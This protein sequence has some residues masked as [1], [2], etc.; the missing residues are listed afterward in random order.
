M[1]LSD[2]AEIQ[3]GLAKGRRPDGATTTR[4]YLRVANV[5]DGRL[6]LRDVKEIVVRECNVNKYTLRRGDVLMTEGGD[7]D[8]LGR[9]AVWQEEVAGCLHQNHV[10][11]IRTDPKRLNP[12]Y[13]AAIARSQYGRSFFLRNAKRT[14]NLASVNRGEVSGFQIPLRSLD[15]QLTWLSDYD[16]VHGAARVLHRRRAKLVNAKTLI[17]GGI[18]H[19]SSAD[20]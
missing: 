20:S 7:F 6:D 3:A 17:L 13:L 19:C 14:S 4:P 8:K 18:S 1:T 9:G 10:F 2:V 15:G 12:W 5:E 16:Q 11:A